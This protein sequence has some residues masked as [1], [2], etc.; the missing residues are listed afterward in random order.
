M[1]DALGLDG[2]DYDWEYPGSLGQKNCPADAVH[3]NC[4]DKNDGKNFA[5]LLRYSRSLLND[6]NRP[7]SIAV[8]A[9]TAAK[10][11]DYDYAGMDKYLSFWN[12]MSYDVNAPTWSPSTAFNAP[13][14]AAQET[15]AYFASRGATPSKLNLGI[16]LYGYRFQNVTSAAVGATPT[17]SASGKDGAQ[18]SYREI[19]QTWGTDDCCSLHEA[20]DGDFY[21]CSSG[22]HVGDWIGVDSP[23]VAKLKAQYVRQHGFGGA[24]FWV[25]P[26]DTDDFAVTRAV[27][28][29]LNNP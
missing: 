4:V 10:S 3:A 19:V 23:R 17:A 22:R 6:E 12:I 16:P 27:H 24:L 18:Y 9:N 29:A 25:I 8:Y 5:R 1:V 21:Y 15:L 7:L 28:D 14:S 13:I 20:D 26:G 11:M 2:I